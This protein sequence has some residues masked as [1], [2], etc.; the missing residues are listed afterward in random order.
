MNERTN[1]MGPC[2]DPKECAIRAAAGPQALTL[3]VLVSLAL[4]VQC[5]VSA[6][7]TA[8]SRDYTPLLGI[9]LGVIVEAITCAGLWTLVLQSRAGQLGRSG[10]GLAR[11][12]PIVMGALM[13]TFALALLAMS[14]MLL[15][16]QSELTEFLGE[17]FEVMNWYLMNYFGANFN[18]APELMFEAASIGFAVLFAVAEMVALRYMLLARFVRKMRLMAAEG[19]APRSYYGFAEVVS[20]LLGVGMA[21][22]GAVV[23]ATAAAAAADII[24][25]GIGIVVAMEGLCIFCTGIVIRVVGHETA[26]AHAVAA[27]ERR[28]PQTP[29]PL[30]RDAGPMEGTANP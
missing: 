13:Q 16:F 17:Y 6:L 12:Q 26:A 23:T 28:E 29:P 4:A 9:S 19:L 1:T 21:L 14:V 24:E 11:V 8:V 3:A 30:G 5:V 27:R 25:A 18:V 20:Y 15:F 2:L 22:S 10:F 7:A